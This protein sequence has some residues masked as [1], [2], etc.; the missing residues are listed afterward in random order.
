M[1]GKLDTQL[2]TIG[3]EIYA[4]VVLVAD[5]RSN[6]DE[7]VAFAETRLHNTWNLIATSS[8][9]GIPDKPA[10]HGQGDARLLE[11]LT[12]DTEYF[13]IASHC[14][15]TVAQE[16]ATSSSVSGLLPNSVVADSKA[17]QQ[18]F[19]MQCRTPFSRSHVADDTDSF[20]A[21][22]GAKTLQIMDW[23]CSDESHEGTHG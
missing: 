7:A 11:L 13:E 12:D 16:A 10:S 3:S 18:V 8:D 1:P 2:S 22:D 15:G 23:A 9:D 14:A 20:G 19:C 17:L 21:G 5:M 4:Q 6:F